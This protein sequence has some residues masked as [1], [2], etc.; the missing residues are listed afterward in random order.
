MRADAA[1]VQTGADAE[2]VGAEAVAGTFAGRAKAAQLALVDGVAGLVWSS[3]GV[4]KV[5]FRFRVTD[6]AITDIDLL[7]DEGELARMDLVLLDR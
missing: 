4:P 7:A 1:A 5:V 6:G 2:V 3:G